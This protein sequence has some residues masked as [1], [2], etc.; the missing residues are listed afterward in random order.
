MLVLSRK[1]RQRLVLGEDV[2]VQVLGVH[3]GQVRLGVEA[4][5]WVHIRRAELPEL[6]DRAAERQARCRTRAARQVIVT[7]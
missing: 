1:V 4:P 7:R 5:P 2:V 6:P 3:G